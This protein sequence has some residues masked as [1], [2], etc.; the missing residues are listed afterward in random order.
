LPE[1]LFYSIIDN[2]MEIADLEEKLYSLF[3]Y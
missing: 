3:I 2:D 1:H